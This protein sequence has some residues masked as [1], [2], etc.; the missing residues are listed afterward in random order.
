MIVNYDTA[1]SAESEWC[2]GNGTAHPTGDDNF[3][4]EQ[5][6]CEVP[7]ADLWNEDTWAFTQGQTIKATVEAYNLR[8]WSV[9]SD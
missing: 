2:F 4:F 6:W 7:M 3:V 8:G 5:R 1:Y 9:A